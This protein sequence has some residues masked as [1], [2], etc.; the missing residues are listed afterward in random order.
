VGPGA[1]QTFREYVAQEERLFA[2]LR[3]A[4]Y[5]APPSSQSPLERYGGGSL[6]ARIA[7]DTTGNRSHEITHPAHRGTAVMLHGL[8]DAPY[9]LQSIGR[10]LH[11][12]AFM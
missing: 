8:S 4:I 5:A 12:R 9:S 3:E 6:A 7:L 2:E 11:P 1:P 10:E